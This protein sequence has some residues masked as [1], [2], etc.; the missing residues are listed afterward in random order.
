MQS[1]FPHPANQCAE[2]AP[3]SACKDITLWAAFLSPHNE[4][5]FATI[6]V[7]FYAGISDEK[8]KM[9]RLRAI[10]AFCLN[11]KKALQSALAIA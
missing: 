7:G 11:L 2:Y 6:E 4:R 8:C 10:S 3:L 9:A 1:I 5:S